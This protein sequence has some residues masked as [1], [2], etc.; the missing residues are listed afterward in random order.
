M[1][2]RF[3]VKH[4]EDANAAQH[5]AAY[6]EKNGGEWT[7]RG[8][9]RGWHHSSGETVVKETPKPEAASKKTSFKKSK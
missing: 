4:N 1:A 2:S 8:S 5:R 6:V 3:W 9:S 7:N